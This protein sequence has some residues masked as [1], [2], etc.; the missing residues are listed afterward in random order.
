MESRMAGLAVAGVS[1]TFGGTRVLS[2]VSL[3][4]V[5][6]EFLTLVGGSGCGKSTLLRV[7]AGLEPQDAGSVSI[8][9]RAVDHLRPKQRNVAMVF[10][11]YAL[12]PHMTVSENIAMPL[13]MARLSFAERLPLLGPLFPRRRG[14]MRAIAAEVEATARQLR[15]EMLLGRKPAQLSGGQR[16][17]VALGRAMVRRP[18][19]FLMD[20]PLS[21]LDAKLRVHMRAELADLHRRLGAT[22]V[23]VTHDQVEAM[24]MSDRVAL[25]DEGRIVQLGRPEDLYHDPADLRVA[26]FIGSPA[27]NVLTG[28]ATAAGVEAG[29]ALLPLAVDLGVGTGVQVGLRPETLSLEPAPGA[30]AIAARLGTVEN[31]G[32]EAI[33]HFETVAEP[34]APL[35]VRAGLEPWL[36]ARASGRLAGVVRIG[37][38]PARALVF[39]GAGRR[40]PAAAMVDGADALVAGAA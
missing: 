26:R 28:R 2:D 31:L 36:R 12:Y 1:K 16:Q 21:N 39:D 29:G 37:V 38:D 19:V 27:M 7:I 22:F 35:V 18:D 14:V 10:Q 6:G 24:T 4:V 25:M 13:V 8:G 3:D 32:A 34:A 17:R 30:P 11:S 33:L 20:E 9:G 15:I 5:D 23:Y 40:V